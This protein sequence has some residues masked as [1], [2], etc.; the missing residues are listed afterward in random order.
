[1]ASSPVRASS[2]PT[3]GGGR[4]PA[5]PRRLS[6][7]G[8]WPYLFI[9]PAGLG[10]AVFYLW[11]ILQTFYFSFTEWG[12]FGGT[13]WAGL[14]N[15]QKLLG[16]PAFY[17]SL[18]NTAVYALIVCSSVPVAVALAALVGSKGLRGAALYRVLYFMPYIAMPVAV[19]MVWRIIFNGDFGVLNQVLALVG[20]DG[21]HWLS[22]PGF[23]VIA[24][25]IVGF[26]ASIGFAMVVIGAGLRSI[27]AELH[28]AAALD[29]AG[30]IRTFFSVTVP[31]LTPTI[32]FVLVVTL[33]GSL[34]LFDLVFA[35]L[36]KANPALSESM[37]LVYYFYKVGFIENE[38]GYAA[39]LA[40]AILLVIG[41]VTYLQF[42]LQRRWV[43]YA[44]D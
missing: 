32:F 40:I 17:R 29:G 33:I 18:V 19:A 21:P 6:S 30:P 27:P 5:R 25:S 7:D 14:E 10:I 26:W 3:R 41:V 34:Q 44:D 22:T 11:P 4:A 2:A 12:M 43:N 28:E 16:D 15:Y 9:A 39:A 36:G 20:V 8:A 42:R 1:M 38:K 35:M 31:L 13:E 24:I 23:S 37:S